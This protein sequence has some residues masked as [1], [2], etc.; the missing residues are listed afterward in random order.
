MITQILIYLDM[1]VYTWGC[2][3][4]KNERIPNNSNNYE[5]NEIS[6]LGSLSSCIGEQVLPKGYPKVTPRYEYSDGV[7]GSLWTI[8]KELLVVPMYIWWVKSYITLYYI[9][10][11]YLKYRLSVSMWNLSCGGKKTSV[12]IKSRG[13]LLSMTDWKRGWS[14]GLAHVEAYEWL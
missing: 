2:T 7:D 11:I 10:I 14:A 13:V 12:E 9:T 5:S 4:V 3:V 6:C 1:Q 8:P